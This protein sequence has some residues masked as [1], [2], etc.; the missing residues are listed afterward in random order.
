MADPC[1]HCGKPAGLAYATRDLAGRHLHLSCYQDLYPDGEG[2]AAERRLA[3]HRAR[4]RRIGIGGVLIL[5]GSAAT[6]SSYEAGSSPGI[7]LAW[8]GVVLA[9]IYLLVWPT[10]PSSD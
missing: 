7:Y 5:M 10:N 3:I 2:E 8:L 1:E 9:G 6:L 4:R